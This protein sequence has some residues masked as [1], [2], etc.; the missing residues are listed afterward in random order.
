VTT[1]EHICQ[2][3][4]GFAPPRLAEDWDNTGL[5]V[6]DRSQ[7]AARIMT[8]L[9]V[10]PASAAE[11]VERGASLIVSHHPSPF[12]PLKRITADSI[13]GQ[14]LLQLIGAGIAVY[15]PHTSFDSATGGIN[16]MLAAGLGVSNPQ[17]LR[18]IPEDPQGL[19]AGRYGDLTEPTTLSGLAARVREFLHIEG[20]HAVGSD[21]TEIKRVAVA[22]GSAG[23]FLGAAR[24][25]GCDVLLTGET[26]FHT[27]LEAEASGVA[28]LLP[29]HYASERFAIE[30]LAG[31][32]QQEFPTLEIWPSQHEA[33]PLRWTQ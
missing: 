20:M 6:G 28:L 15:S 31:V 29:G 1:I 21:T 5:L 2:F 23:S 13:T 14:I 26:T 33:D 4:A 11:A 32:L 30:Q 24:R 18:D 7:S 25:K 8:C 27:C 17:N 9:T 3:L 12:K 19:G 16:Q 10:T 22:C